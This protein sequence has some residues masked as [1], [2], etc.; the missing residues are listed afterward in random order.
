[1]TVF[2]PADAAA[3]SVGADEVALRLARQPGVAVV[4]TGSRGLAW[5]EPMIEVATDAGR[6][7]YGP[8]G[9]AD[10]DSLMSAG[11]RTGGQHRL[12]LGPPEDIP[13]LRGQDRVTF[14]RVGV[15]DPASPDD[16]LAHGGL[17]GLT[18]ALAMDPDQVIEEVVASGLRGRGGAG[19]PTGIKWRT[20]RQ[21][22]GATAYL[23]CN[24]DE[25]DSGSY[26]DRM[27]IEADPFALIE[28]MA[29][30]AWAVGAH[31]GFVYLRSE[32]PDAIAR[33][34]QAV[35]LARQRGWLGA[36]LLGSGF[37]FDIEVQVGAGAYI[38][39]EETALLESLEG[40]RPQVRAKPPLPAIAGLFGAP[41]VIN[42]VL[43]L[44]TLPA[45]LADGA[46]A[47]A[48]RGQARS[49]GTQ[50]FQLSGNVARGGIVEVGFGVTLR[51]LVEDWG[52]GTASGRPVGAIQVGGPLGAYLGPDQLDV[53]LEY[54]A[55]AQAG[56]MLGHGGIVVFDDTVDLV[57]QARCAMAF[58][59]ESSC[60]K[61][62][63]CRIGSTRGV[64]LLDRIRS[65]ADQQAD[66]DLLEDLCQV[67]AEASLC[68]LGGLTPAPVRSALRLAGLAAH[69]AD[70]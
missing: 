27:L 38:C 47:Y 68:P 53:P 18:R 46:G 63:P 15:I 58:C 54:E 19:F 65:G 10:I 17:A 9:A 64:E 69:Q 2:V 56:A 7:A 42:N 28:G 50:V 12:R 66:L 40:R 13:W 24:A 16:W 30:A 70:S 20:V 43:T 21:A 5:L 26:A 57:G 3:R 31:Q 1:V 41:T 62:T 55:M 52:G 37:A 51:E 29:I 22:G 34:N 45:I 6:I 67:M 11:L 4:R 8:V 39:G 48:A 44:G 61:C 25:G 33:L 60:G 35:S 32:Y 49:R 59:A 23:V 36:D 14:A